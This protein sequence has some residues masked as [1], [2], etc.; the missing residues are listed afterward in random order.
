MIRAEPAG[1]IWFLLFVSVLAFPM[2]LSCRRRVTQG[3]CFSLV[4]GAAAIGLLPCG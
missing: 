4:P 2:K 1:D 3:F